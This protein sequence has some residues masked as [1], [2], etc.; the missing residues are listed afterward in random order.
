MLVP[1]HYPRIQKD[2][3]EIILAIME[4]D[5][6]RNALLEAADEEEIWEIFRKSAANHSL[7]LNPRNKK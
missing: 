1:G 3:A 2:I 4:D 5:S 6:V 7:S